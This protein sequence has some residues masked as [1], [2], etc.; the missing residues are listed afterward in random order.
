MMCFCTPR[1][2]ALPIAPRRTGFTVSPATFGQDVSGCHRL[3]RRGCSQSS[4]LCTYYFAYPL[5]QLNIPGLLPLPLK[6]E[7]RLTAS[8]CLGPVRKSCTQYSQSLIL[9]SDVR[10]VIVFDACR[11]ILCNCCTGCHLA[12]FLL[13]SMFDTISQPLPVSA[14][15]SSQAGLQKYSPNLCFW[16]QASR[17]QSFPLQVPAS[18]Q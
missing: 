12:D 3:L 14:L 9:S 15:R 2:S 6:Q 13:Q 8:I 5:F 18:F 11:N 16:I 4:C 1:V 17:F 10:E 7:S